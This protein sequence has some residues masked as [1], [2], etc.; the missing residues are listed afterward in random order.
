MNL[1]NSYTNLMWFIE[2]TQVKQQ[3]PV[4]DWSECLMVWQISQAAFHLLPQNTNDS[5]PLA[6]PEGKSGNPWASPR[7]TERPAVDMVGRPVS[8]LRPLEEQENCRVSV[9]GRSLTT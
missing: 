9:G 6:F 5:A 4:A 1:F 3:I 7:K 2:F 8:M